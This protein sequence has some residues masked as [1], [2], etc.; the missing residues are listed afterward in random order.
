MNNREMKPEILKVTGCTK[1]DELLSGISYISVGAGGGGGGGINGLRT[2]YLALTAADS[3]HSN[4][5]LR[6]QRAG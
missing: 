2:N 3:W 5:L 6:E 4:W 1:I